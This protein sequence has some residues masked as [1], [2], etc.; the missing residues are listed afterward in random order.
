MSRLL[1]GAVEPYGSQRN[2]TESDINYIESLKSAKR[3]A[4]VASWRNLLR[5]ATSTSADILYHPSGAPY[6]VDSSDFIS[7]SHSSTHLAVM[8]SSAPCAIDLESTTRNFERI[9][10][11]YV[12]PFESKLTASTAPLLPLLWSAKEVLYKISPLA[13]LDLLEDI[14]VI[15]IEN[16][17]IYGV[18]KGCDDTIEMLYRLQDEHVIVYTSSA[19]SEIKTTISLL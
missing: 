11:R 1:F 3:Q 5:E 15:A 4:E 12:T 19:E 2:L 6:I 16:G 8:V 7:V 18:V 9:A 17:V 10:S 14:N 13:G